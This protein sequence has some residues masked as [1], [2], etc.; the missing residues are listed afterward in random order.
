MLKSK[1][2]K[3]LVI[4]HLENISGQVLD[5]YPG[6][7]KSI[8]KGKAGIYALYRKDKLYYVGLAINL[9]NRLKIHL[10][11][12]HRGAWDRFSVF[13][14]LHNEH[15]KELESLMLRINHPPGNKV[16][17]AFINSQSLR[18]QIHK[19]I[20]EHSEDKIALLMG[21]KFADRR[22]KT[23][24]SV[25]KGIS[26]IVGMVERRRIL[27]AKHKGK[28]YVATLRKDGSIGYKG[29]RYSSPT[30]VAKFVTGRKTIN[31]WDFWKIK[32][33]KN[34]WVKLSELRK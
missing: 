32:G 18:N 22:R 3:H 33:D 30:A 5:E 31:G 1:R 7:I 19:K 4:Q 27:I 21:G 16:G 20:K 6:V 11:D 29:K 34:S 8:I 2:Q 23:K 24:M 9:M 12:R 14:T 25:G 28:K 13:L 15:M 17:G 10:K 26:D